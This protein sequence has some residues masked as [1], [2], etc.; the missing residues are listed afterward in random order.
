MSFEFRNLTEKDKEEIKKK[1]QELVVSFSKKLDALNLREESSFIE[2]EFSYREE[3]DV[4]CE[5]GFR[6]KIL[7]NAK[8]KTKEHIIAKEK[9]W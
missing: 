4:F 1:A 9:K 7:K 3:G 2:R 5:E 8:N 6:E